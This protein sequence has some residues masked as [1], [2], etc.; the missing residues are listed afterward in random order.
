MGTEI[1]KRRLL[2]RVS[3]VAGESQFR[4][5]NLAAFVVLGHR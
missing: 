4:L 3:V 2:V 5:I 1:V